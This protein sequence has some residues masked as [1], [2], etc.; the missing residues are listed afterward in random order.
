[1]KKRIGNDFSF[2]WILTENG[3]PVDVSTV[4]DFALVIKHSSMNFAITPHFDIVD[5]NP[6]IEC[7]KD[8][9]TQLGKYYLIATWKTPEAYYTD[10]F[11]A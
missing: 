10:G 5:G 2:L 3:T 9:L 11:R 1:M 6:I 8:Q 7:S 4:V